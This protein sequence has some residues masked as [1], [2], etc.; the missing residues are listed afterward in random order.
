MKTKNKS[1]AQLSLLAAIMA[2]VYFPQ[3]SFARDEIS[4]PAQTAYLQSEIKKAQKV[5]ADK[6]AAISGVSA[7]KIGKIM[8]VDWRAGDPKFA[9][10]PALEKERG[11]K[12]SDEQ[13][14]QIT[15]AD[16]EMKEVIE[17][18]RVEAK[19]R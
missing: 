5:F 9:I 8:P 10:I 7:D 2:T 16:R 1:L 11:A 18:A 4:T 3:Q 6:A 19:K 14:Q 13:R 17:R 12:L 15:A